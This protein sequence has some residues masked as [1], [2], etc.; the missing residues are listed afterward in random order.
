MTQ[1]GVPSADSPTATPRGKSGPQI[2]R[3]PVLSTEHDD[4]TLAPFTVAHRAGLQVA[5]DDER[6]AL[7]MSN[8]FPYPYRDVDAEWWISKCLAEDPP[9]SFVILVDGTV[10][11]GVGCEPHGDIR[12]GTAEVGWWLAPRWWGRGIAAVAV[13]R[14]IDYCF[15]DLDLH[16]VEAGVF[17]TNVASARV[18]EKAGFVFDGVARDGYLKSGDLV[19]RLCYGLARSSLDAAGGA[20]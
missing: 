3:P 2:E 17:S 15:V 19:D 1:E 13:R 14:F 6:I 20:D 8:R 5:A 7:R 18:A 10:A 11:G 9:V 4:V 12:T 16:R